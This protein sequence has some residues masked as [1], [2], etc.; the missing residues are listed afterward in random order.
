LSTAFWAHPYGLPVI[1]WPSDIETMTRQ[2][3]ESFYKTYYGPNNAVVGI[4]GDIDANAVI[5]LMSETFGR[6]PASG[7][8][9]PVGIVE[10]E[11]AGERRVEIEFEAE[12]R[13]M[14]GFHK[15]EVGSKDDDVFDVI[16]SIL[17]DGR[18]SRL[19]RSLVKEKR[20]AVSVST[21]SG[22]PGARYS[23]LFVIDAVPRAPHTTAELEEAITVELERLKTEPVEAKDLQKTLNQLDAYL[24]HSLKSNSGLASQ[25]AYY[26]AVAGDWR[27]LVSSHDRIAQ[28]TLEDI[29]RVARKY[30]VKKNRVLGALTKKHD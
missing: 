30:F 27:Y 11:Q 22:T 4:V 13:L 28:V 18:S 19:Y 21:S 24:I 1:G 29:Q 15:P 7:E 12:P 20:L 9:V 26:E 5:R 16:D 8:P 10:P 25:L 14:M 17:G 6:I 2:E 23:N 3:T